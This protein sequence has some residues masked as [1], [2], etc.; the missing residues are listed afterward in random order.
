MVVRAP[1]GWDAAAARIGVGSA[2]VA[3]LAQQPLSFSGMART[4]TKQWQVKRSS[5]A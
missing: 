2:F 3:Q 5:G 1:V 4:L